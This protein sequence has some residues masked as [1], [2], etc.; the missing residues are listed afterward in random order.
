MRRRLR[1]DL[2]LLLLK[3]V[4]KMSRQQDVKIDRYLKVIK[5]Y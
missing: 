3:I 5:L 1:E 2:T 4:M